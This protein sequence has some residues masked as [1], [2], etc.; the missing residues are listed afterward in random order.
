VVLMPLGKDSQ[1]NVLSKL[2]E[3]TCPFELDISL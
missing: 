1:Q 3:C 2:R